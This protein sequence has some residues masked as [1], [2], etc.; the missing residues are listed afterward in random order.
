MK[1]VRLV[2][3]TLYV[4]FFFLICILKILYKIIHYRSH[5]IF[6]IDPPGAKDLDDALSCTLLA[7]G[8][9]EVGIHIADVTHFLK[10]NTP[11]DNDARQKAN[12]IYLTETVS[13]LTTD[14][15]KS[16]RYFILHA[17]YSFRF[18]ICC[19]QNCVSYV[20]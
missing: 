14:I 2:R 15:I 10:P 17:F 1:K 12:S 4:A 16:C 6:T 7:N 18:F 8:N 5:C 9:V 20:L 13:V 19:Q 11:L 3:N